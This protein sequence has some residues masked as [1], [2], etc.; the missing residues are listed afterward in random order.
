MPGTFFGLETAVRSLRAHQLALDVTN[1][2]V[3]NVH[4]PGYSRQVAHLTATNPYTEA[5]LNRPGQPGQVGTGVEVAAIQRSRD[6]FLDVRYRSEIALMRQAEASH[7]ALEGVE[8]IFA[9]PSDLGL[10]GAIGA[11]FA[12]WQDLASEP[13]D[14]AVR[15]V[16]A[17]RSA[18]LASSFRRIS[19]QL[20]VQR[21]QLNDQVR[22]MVQQV[23]ALANQI[24]TLNQQIVRNEFGGQHA[25]DLRDRRDALLDEIAG[26][27]PIV[28]TSNPDGSVDVLLGGRALVQGGTVDSLVAQPGAG[29]MDEVRFSS[30]L[31]L[32]SLTSGKLAGIIA[33]RDQMLPN[34]LARLDQL[35]SDIISAVNALHSAGY[36]LDGTTGRPLF[37]GVD[38]TTIALNPALETDPRLLAAAD[39]PGQDGNSTTALAIAQ[40]RRTMVPPP[41]SR[42]Q[43]LVSALGNDIQANQ[44]LWSTQAAVVEFIDRQR[45]SV[46]GV[47]LDEEAAALVRYQRAYEAAARVVTAIDQMLDKLINGTGIV[48]R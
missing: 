39:A 28:V 1:H 43:E 7:A 8:S 35:A 16:T 4:T 33:V 30:D 6:P 25:N 22:Q 3:A 41:E 27:A 20:S 5:G 31:A 26:I 36:A 10:S 46:S 21:Q 34:Y 37:T 44:N 32:A 14:S 40:L 13:T 29:G 11:F 9:E 38:A 23:N 42:Y 2:N 48:G 17:R 47:S 24:A 15:I 12:S 45:Q 18:E 19:G